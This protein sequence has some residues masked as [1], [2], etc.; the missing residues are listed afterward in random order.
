MDA[1]ASSLFRIIF[2][3]H[4][5]RIVIVDRLDCSPIDP[6]ASIESTIPKLDN[7]KPPVENL[8]V[9]MHS[10]LMG[11]FDISP[12]TVHINAISSSRTPIR[13]EFFRTH[14]FSDPWTLLSPTST[15]A[16]GQVGGMAFPMSAVEIAYQSIIDSAESIRAPLS[17]EE[18]DGDVAPAWTL[19]SSSAQDCLYTTLPTE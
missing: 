19:S 2:F 17:L 9:G 6:N 14:Y 4:E 11:T 10:S 3:P 15:L 8:G 7:A 18:L 1:I 13:R 5:G 12:P 16:E